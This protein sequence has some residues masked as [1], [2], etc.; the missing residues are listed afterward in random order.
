[1]QWLLLQQK[2]PKDFVIAMGRQF[3]VR[4]FVNTA[5]AEMGL[6]RPRQG[7]GLEELGMVAA[8]NVVKLQ[9]AA[10]NRQGRER[11]LK[12]GDVIA[13]V[14]QRS[15]RPT[16][17]ETLPGNPAQ[18]KE[19]LGWEPRTSFEDMV[20][21]IMC[22]DLPLS[23]RDAVCTVIGFKTF[24]CIYPKLCPQPI[25]EAY[26][27]TGPLE[28][29]NDA[30]ALA[31]IAGI[32]M[33]QAYRTQY[34]F[35]AISAMPTNLYGPGDNYHPENSHVIPALIRRFHEAKLSGAESGTIWGTGKALREFLYVDDMAEACV[36][37]LENYSDFEHVNVGNGVGY[38]IM[39]T[40]RIV[41]SMVGFE[42]EIVADATKPDGTPRKLLDSCELEELGWKAGTSL[43]VGLHATYAEYLSNCLEAEV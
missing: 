36:F 26:L 15:F 21:E 32:K 20:I 12:P 42:G 1:M 2:E 16:E 31:K 13:R 25:K 6:T 37:L 41:A 19:K 10:G 29:T 14:D 5:A 34:G 11:H 9:Q 4:D 43:D 17:V 8:M 22:E 27:L 23:M 28:P 33:C 40:A 24:C 3:T 7:E 30:C 18:A 39:E 35:D 38:T